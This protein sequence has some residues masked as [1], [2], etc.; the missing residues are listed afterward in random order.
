MSAIGSSY[1]RQKLNL[2][3]QSTEIEVPHS[4]AANTGQFVERIHESNIC[5]CSW[6]GTIVISNRGNCYSGIE[7]RIVQSWHRLSQSNIRRIYYFTDLAGFFSIMVFIPI[8]EQ[9]LVHLSYFG[10][11][12]LQL[13]YPK[14]IHSSILVSKI[15][16]WYFRGNTV[17]PTT[18][19]QFLQ[20]IPAVPHS[21]GCSFRTRSEQSDS[22]DF[23]RI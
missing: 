16:Y 20:G 13:W 3:I 17:C 15:Q 19:R 12:R 22:C 1:F 9:Q 5:S 10:I 6:L 4:F 8:P 7:N 11:D 18:N 14:V 2:Q 23:V 21:I